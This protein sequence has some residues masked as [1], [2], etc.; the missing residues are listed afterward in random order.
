M[1]KWLQISEL[2]YADLATYAPLTNL[3]SN[4]ES[5]I[6]PLIATPDEGDVFIVYYA[7]YED[8]PSKD[9]V[10][11]FTITINA[12]A[13]T[14]NKAIAVAD[15]VTNAIKASIN[16]YGI[17]TGRPVFNEQDE[18]YLEQIFTIKK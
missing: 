12:F 15:E 2:V 17:S 18:F 16:V 10:F 7:S 9:G 13:P 6:Y 5:S 1:S 3:L 11:S 14:Y 4:N 8:K